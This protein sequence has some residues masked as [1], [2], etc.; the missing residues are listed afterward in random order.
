MVWLLILVNNELYQQMKNGLPGSKHEE[1]SKPNKLCLGCLTGG[2][3]SNNPSYN[4]RGEFQASKGG[5][6]DSAFHADGNQPHT[7]QVPEQGG[8]VI[9]EINS[10]TGGSIWVEYEKVTR[11]V[12]LKQGTTIK[13]EIDQEAL[14]NE[15]EPEEMEAY[16]QEDKEEIQKEL[17]GDKE[18]EPEP[19]KED[20]KETE[21][22]KEDEQEQEQET[23]KENEKETETEKEKEKE[24]EKEKEGEKEKKEDEGEKTEDENEGENEDE[25]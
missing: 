22:E 2:G 17:G 20:E 5:A 11:K 24:R 7:C 3:H 4:Y 12:K 10:T 21:Q 1:P 8:K 15:V 25:Q 14:E 6:I 13:Q 18:K 9:V 19:E 23:E 16:E